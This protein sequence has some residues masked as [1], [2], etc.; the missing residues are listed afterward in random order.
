VKKKHVVSQKDKND[1]VSYA[2]KM[3][4]VTS[5]EN[6]HNINYTNLN[7]IRKLDL[8][9]FSLQDAN[10]KVKK[11]IIESYNYQYA[12]LLVVTGKGLRSKSYDNPYI[13]EKMSILKYSVPEFIKSNNNLSSKIKK[14]T[15]ADLKDGGEGAF[16]IF[17]KKKL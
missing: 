8:H 5:K 12:K 3:D 9:G 1:W 7:K 10:R 17:L 2:K 16:Y 11:F 6:D 15:E 13:S 14:I 4:D